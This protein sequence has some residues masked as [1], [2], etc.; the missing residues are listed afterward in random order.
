MKTFSRKRHFISAAL[1]AAIVA[2][3]AIAGAQE[4]TPPFA[5]NR[6]QPSFAG[7]RMFGVPSPFVAG[8]FTP[9]AMV[10]ADYAHNPLV[11]RR[12][13][14]DLGT[15]V[16]SQLFLHLN[17]GIALWNR[18]GI[19]IDVPFAVFQDGEG[20][21]VGSRQFTSP[22]DAQMGDLRAGL[23]LRILGEYFD[24]FQVAVGGYIW[25]PTGNGDPGSYVSDGAIR[26]LPQLILGGLISER[27]IW[28][29]A[30]G[31][32]IRSESPV[33]INVQQGTSFQ[34]G[35]GLGYL[36][37]EK[38]NFQ[39]GLE[40]YIGTVL[41]DPNS[42]NT[43]AELLAGV[44]IRPIDNIEIG[45]GAGPGLT[46]GQG[47][48][49]FRGVAMLAYT[50]KQEKPKPPPPDR[51]KDGIIDA[52]DA[53]PDT[54]GVASSDPKK[55]GCP[56]IDTDKD[57]IPDDADAC[58]TEPGPK[59]DDP[60]K[61]GC[62]PPPDKDKDGIPDAL[63]ACVDVPGVADPDPKKNGCPPDKDGDGV[64]DADDACVDIPG[65]KTS[66]PATNGCPGDNDKDTIRND[67]DACPNEA[68]KPDPDP[69]KHGCPVA[70]RVTE[71]E[72][73]ILQQVQF[74]TARATIKPVSN[75][76]LDEV[77][78]VLKEHPEIT[79]IE[80]QGHTDNRGGEAYN[81]R[82]SDNR[83]KA[84][85]NALIKRGIEAGR[86]SSKGYGLSEPIGDNATEAGRAMN[87]RVQFKILEKAP[88]K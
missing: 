21:T 52:E 84:V 45:L 47:T 76:L 41:E 73:I 69:K 63:D 2:S 36:L 17:A 26:A 58:P 10:M 31:P 40:S 13:G 72:I 6:F 55:H 11:L 34:G 33:L 79:K 86:L 27:F 65:L 8:R 9:H 82:L 1:G 53:C 68:G 7:D 50:P 35:V 24:P 48:P 64:Y 62:P 87:R 49:S 46:S 54:P 61:N 20:P 12:D 81:K 18:V 38:K 56:V 67:K 85:M 15:V 42:R 57:G 74:D 39:V 37:G 19:N 30:L 78:A 59:N 60:K 28:T 32:E 14:E 75:A 83:S 80:V 23:R 66:D 3:T 4:S 5:L 22:T 29:A 71:Q 77:A 88:K 43:N 25:F 70:V 51:D 16:S 44:R